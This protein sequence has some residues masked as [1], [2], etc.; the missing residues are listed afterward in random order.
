MIMCFCLSACDESAYEEVS[1]AQDNPSV[2]NRTYL[3][4]GSYYYDDT[5]YRVYQI[6]TL[7][8]SLEKNGLTMDL[9]DMQYYEVY[10]S[11]SHGYTG[12]VIIVFDRTSISD[13]DIYWISKPKNVSSEFKVGSYYSE[14]GSTDAERIPNFSST[15]DSEHWFFIFRTTE[16]SRYPLKDGEIFMQAFWDSADE[17]KKD[18]AFYYYLELDDSTDYSDLSRLTT[19]EIGAITSAMVDAIK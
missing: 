10:S 2:K 11:E 8:F 3:E 9:I 5:Y 6:E 4:D 15:Y 14:A 18:S 7:P 13:D 12:Y 19:D 17:N 1:Y 16:T